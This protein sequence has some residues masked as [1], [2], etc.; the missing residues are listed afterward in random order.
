MTTKDKLISEAVE[1]FKL[2]FLEKVSDFDPD[3]GEGVSPDA[4]AWGIRDE[5]IADFLSSELS[6]AIDKTGEE[7]KVTGETSDG[8]HTF[9]ELYEFRKLYNAALFNEWFRQGKYDVKKSKRHNDRTPC[10]DGNWFIVQ[11]TLPTGQISNHY[12]MKDWDLFQCDEWS[13]ADVWDGHT[14]QDVAKRLLSTLTTPKEES[15]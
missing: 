14:A 10:F 9:N 1:R 7:N 5:E 6:P 12:E 11:A 3:P 13:A 8:Y 4:Y 2:K 15:K